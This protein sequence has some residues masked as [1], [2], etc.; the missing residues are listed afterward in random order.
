MLDIDKLVIR[1]F[2]SYGNYDTEIDIGRLSQCLITGEYVE[3]ALPFVTADGEPSDSDKSNGA[4]KSTIPNGILWCLFGRTM[5]AAQP[6]DRVVNW[7]SGKDCRASLYLANG[8]VI[9]RTRKTEGHN[10]LVV[11][12]GGEAILTTLSTT[13]N[14]QAELAR[15]YGLDW[16]I[17]T[18][19]SFFTQY[20]R[21][22][23]EM[24]EPQR[25]AVLERLLRLDRLSLYADV[26][27]EKA[28]GMV[29]RQQALADRYA[30][31]EQTI[32]SLQEE[33]AAAEEAQQSYEADRA[34][35]RRRASDQ[36]ADY[37]QRAAAVAV[38]DAAELRQLW[39]KVEQVKQHIK[40]L[41]E[42]Q[43][44]W[45]LDAADKQRQAATLQERIAA[46]EAKAGKI[47]LECEQQVA[48]THIEHKVEPLE[49]REA[50]LARE[51]AAAYAKVTFLQARIIGVEQR[52]A[53]VTPTVTVREAEV[54]AAQRES[55]LEAAE[56]A[57]EQ[58]NRIR[59][60]RNPHGH[61]S[62]RLAG[63]IAELQESLD[64]VQQDQQRL[65]V[66]VKHGQYI[67]RSYHDRRK[68]KQFGIA[69]HLPFFNSRLGHYLDAF[70]LD[71]KIA[72]TDNL[73]VSSDRWGY[74]FLSGG[75]RKRA[76]LSFMFAAF[77]LH[78]RLYGRQCNLLVLDEVDGRLDERG[79]ACLVNVIKG[80]LARRVRTLLIISHRDQMLDTFPHQITV[81][82]RDRF[83]LLG[84]VR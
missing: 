44:R 49:E 5:H 24:A 41:Q 84:E 57:R 77:D 26:A 12:R 56:R 74:D 58:A 15:L 72:L 19:S 61:T 83:S 18:G 6:G 75:E 63:K 59:L 67:Q 23:L 11:E 17:F 30:A 22:W 9:T 73:G 2:L 14:Q 47:C 80:D 25:K 54:L 38:P 55:L 68:I 45:Q 48:T 27:K 53:E 62:E 70:E 8:D 40:A 43:R 71:V 46:W 1:N 7:Y 16:S 29:T 10:E 82:R 79:I 52:L 20:G 69:K 32:Q 36:A 35:R 39:Q 33:L 13:P 31:Q 28:A 37:Q 60:E 64:G 50:V 51:A 76:D 78:E 81:Q 42:E 65:D 34:E 21:P 3:G 66:L 4:G